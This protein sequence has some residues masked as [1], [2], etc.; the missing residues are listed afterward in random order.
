MNLNRQKGQTLTAL[1]VFMV[2]AITVT[3]GA[4]TLMSLNLGNVQR[5]EMGTDILLAAESGAENALMRLLRNP[6][7]SGETFTVD[8]ATVT[9]TVNGSSIVSSATDGKFT[10][11]IQV[12]TVYTNNILAVS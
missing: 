12:D 3:A 6:N 1:L 4:A 10:R 8:Q 2:I 9:I 11:K 5:V 7:Y